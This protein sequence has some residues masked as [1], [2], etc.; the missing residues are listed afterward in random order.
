VN[1]QF[2]ATELPLVDIYLARE[3]ARQGD[4]DGAIP[5]M[6]AS[7]DAIFANG[8][9]EYSVMCTSS[10]VEALLD[11]AADGDVEEAEAVIARLATAPVRD[12]A[13]CDIALLRLRALLARARGDGTAY[14]QLS[15]RYHA[16]ASNLGFEGHM[17]LAQAMV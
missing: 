17:A 9:F 13:V 10:L 4:A 6:R 5:I 14:R 16:M 1:G 3:Q 2:F 15:D 11:R 8:Q 7:V 12:L